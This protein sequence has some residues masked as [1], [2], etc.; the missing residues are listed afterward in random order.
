[1]NLPDDPSVGHLVS[2]AEERRVVVWLV[3]RP[4]HD[5][6]LQPPCPS[7][8]EAPPSRL[9]GLAQ[10]SKLLFSTPLTQMQRGP[11]GSSASLTTFL[12][13]SSHQLDQLPLRADEEQRRAKV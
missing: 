10:S 7:R 13:P 6:A 5:A 9:A 4:G 2:V 12:S 3:V 1:M 11:T 8:A